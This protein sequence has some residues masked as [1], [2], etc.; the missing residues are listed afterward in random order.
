[1]H[2]SK[3][4]FALAERNKSTETADLLFIE[5]LKV[6]GKGFAAQMGGFRFHDTVF[7]ELF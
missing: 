6:D 2:P 1:L 7:G 5:A 3:G 4:G